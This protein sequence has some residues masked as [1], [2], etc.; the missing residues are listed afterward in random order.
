LYTFRGIFTGAVSE[1][2]F[3]GLNWSFTNLVP[4][5]LSFQIMALNAFP[6]GENALLKKS[7][8]YLPGF[9]LRR[10]GVSEQYLRVTGGKDS[11]RTVGSANA[12]RRS[13]NKQPYH[14]E[15]IL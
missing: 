13:T 7:R 3:I 4:I 1:P 9:Y 2:S 12:L 15:S 14:S 11:R 6:G 5:T 10:C 8:W